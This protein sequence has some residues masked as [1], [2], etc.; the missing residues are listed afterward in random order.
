MAKEKKEK[1]KPNITRRAAIGTI[2][3]AAVGGGAYYVWDHYSGVIRMFLGQGGGSLKNMDSDEA[4]DS[5]ELGRKYIEEIQGEGTVLLK[6]DDAT[7]PLETTKVNLFGIRAYK[8]VYTGGG[9]SGANRDDNV[10]LPDALKDRGIEINEQ[11]YNLYVNWSNDEIISTDT[12]QEKEEETV[13]NEWVILF[14][15]SEEAE[16]SAEGLS[17]DIMSQAKNYSD[18]AIIVI[19]RSGTEGADA[20]ISTF[21]LDDD[22]QAM[23][24]TVCDNF[25]KVIVLLNTGAYM[26]CS[27]IADKPQIT[28]VLYAGFPGNTGWYAVADILKGTINPSGRTADTW[29]ADIEDC[30][31]MVMLRDPK[32]AKVGDRD[33]FC[34]TNITGENAFFCNYYEGIYVGYR[35]YETRFGADDAEFG[36]KVVWPF[37]YGL[38]YTNFRWESMGMSYD[39]DSETFTIK[40]KVDNQGEVAGKDVIEVYVNAPYYDD[41]KIEKSTAKLVGFLK[42][43]ELE[44]G[45]GNIYEI[46]VP[47]RELASYDYINDK[48]YVLDEGDYEFRISR[49]SH[50]VVYT[51]TWNLAEKRL[52]DVSPITG[53]KIENAFD[54]IS[55]AGGFTYLSRADWEGTWTSVD[56]ISFEATN[57]QLEGYAAT[58]DDWTPEETYTGA[59][60]V[61]GVDAGLTLDQMVEVDYDDATWDTL[62]EQLTF[63]EAELLC[64]SGTYQTM[65]IERL[66]VPFASAADGPVGITTLYTGDSGMDYNCATLLASTWSEDMA[67]KMGKGVGREGTAYGITYWYGP[68]MD[69]HRTVLGGR[70]YEYYSEDGFLAGKIAAATVRGADEEGLTAVIKHYAVNDQDN[71]RDNGIM[72]WANEQAIREIYLKPFQMAIEEGGARG[73]MSMMNRLGNHWASGDY[74]LCTQ[75]IRTE[76]GFKGY[77][78]TDATGMDHWPFANFTRAL[79]AGNDLMLANGGGSDTQR[80]HDKGM[81]APKTYEKAL[82]DGCKHIL[83]TVSRSSA[84]YTEAHA[85]QMGMPGMM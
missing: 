4:L 34:Y 72:N 63:D 32:W 20:D 62:V 58:I 18:V 65:E 77:I 24:D 3:A 76:W 69:C 59:D 19:A 10:T 84:M 42:T 75:T 30:P 17:A 51:E 9:S 79:M 44:P 37:G 78:I 46:T 70:N 7:L 22:E 64:S 28:G 41:R 49:D 74:G 12:P 35:Y 27:W 48:T 68:G 25:E 29:A 52:L 80:M 36:K 23:V 61:W 60:Q 83:Y 67:F 66:G 26:D 6:N 13:T 45:W 39:E 47:L 5:R 40:V 14:G 21:Y 56:D 73:V 50:N 71:N 31:A 81:E 15:G 82:H 16:L 43:P 1:K 85:K 55:N 57:A 38:S 2:A 8:S 33:G 11:L 53:N 54:D